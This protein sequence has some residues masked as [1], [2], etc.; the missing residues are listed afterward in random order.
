[1]EFEVRYSSSQAQPYYWRIVAANGRVLATSETYRHHD[2]AVSA[3]HTVQGNAAA[4]RIVDYTR[5]AA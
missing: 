3:I 2:D 1:M 4:A 5:R